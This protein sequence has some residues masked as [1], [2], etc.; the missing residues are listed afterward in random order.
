VTD[1]QDPSVTVDDGDP[2]GENGWWTSDQ[3]AVSVSA[4]DD[5]GVASVEAAVDGGAWA[6]AGGAELT[7]P[8]TGDGSHDVKAR[9]TDTTGNR[10][11]ATSLA[12]KIDA[13]V[14]LS[15][16]TYDASRTVEVRAADATSGVDRIEVMVGDGAWSTYTGPIAVGEDGA[17]IHYRSVD[18]AGNVEVTNELVVPAAWANLLPSS[19]VA[20]A[21][22]SSVRFGSTAMVRVRVNGSAGTPT[23]VVRVFS[24]SVLLASGQLAADGRIRM[25]VDTRSLGGPGG[26][27]LV[28]RYDGDETYRFSTDTVEI[29]VTKGT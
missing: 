16:A 2:D 22:A 21:E 26:Y 4:T 15:R 23:G 17:M 6:S 19:T 25:G 20:V 12:L 14:P 8:V 28:V 9:A 18:R 5:T 3:V 13:T 1:A 7:V 11:A 29:K 10:S 27:T 24:G